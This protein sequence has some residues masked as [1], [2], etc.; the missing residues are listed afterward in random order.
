MGFFFDCS[1]MLSGSALPAATGATHYTGYDFCLDMRCGVPRFQNAQLREELSAS[2]EQR[3]GE[4]AGR[5]KAEKWGQ[6][7]LE[8]SQ[9]GAAGFVLPAIG[10]VKSCFID[11]QGT[12][13]Q[14]G[15]ATAS[16]AII[17][18]EKGI[19]PVTLEGLA[20]HSHVWVL[21]IFHKNNNFSKVQQANN[22]RGVTF[23]SKVKPPRS[24]V[25]VGVLATR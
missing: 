2:Q 15:L 3:K 9:A 19:S 13:R 21:F 16:R 4:V 22:Q 6:K 12:P 20:E 17:S 7:L 24:P 18:L 8:S 25:K 23:P 11:C 5:K 10:F 14:P 1:G